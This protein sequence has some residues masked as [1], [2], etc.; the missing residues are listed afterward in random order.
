[1]DDALKIR[2]STRDI[3]RPKFDDEI[4][5]SIPA[6]PPK[7][8]LKKRPDRE[9]SLQSPELADMTAIMPQV[10]AILARPLSSCRRLAGRNKQRCSERARGGCCARHAAAER[11]QCWW[12]RWWQCRRQ[13]RLRR[14]FRRLQRR[15]RQWRQWR[16]CEAKATATCVG[17]SLHTDLLNS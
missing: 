14:R 1:M 3:K 2:R 13:R 17:Q 9:R 10:R 8:L 12:Q 11:R 7:G 4:V 6:I 15:W 5:Q 16:C